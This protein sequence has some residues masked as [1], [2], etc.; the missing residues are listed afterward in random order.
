MIL[1]CQNRRLERRTHFMQIERSFG[2]TG[3]DVDVV[4]I[5]IPTIHF[6]PLTNSCM[7]GVANEISFNVHVRI[8]VER[9]IV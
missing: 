7:Q 8:K 6:C 2:L 5:A 4:P 3:L 9:F 1:L